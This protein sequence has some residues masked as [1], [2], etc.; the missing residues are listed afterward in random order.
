ML[1]SPAN[2]LLRPIL[3]GP[4]T[5]QTGKL[6]HC[7]CVVWIVCSTFLLYFGA[8]MKMYVNLCRIAVRLDPNATEN[9]AE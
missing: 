8:F 3:L 7:L 4:G 6:F 9:P 5:S 2:Q 1:T